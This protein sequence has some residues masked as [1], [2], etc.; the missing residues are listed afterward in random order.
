MRFLRILGLVFI[1]ARLIGHIACAKACLN[2]AARCRHRFG[3]HV[4]AIGA[5]IGDMPCLIQALRRRHAGLG[6][7][8]KLA[9]CFLLQGAGHKGRVRVAR[10]GLGFDR[11]HC[12]IALAHRRCRQIGRLGA[13]NVKFIQLFARQMGQFCGKAL[14]ARRGQQRG[15]GPEFARAKGLDLHLAV[16]DQ[17]QANRLHPPCRPRA[18]Q[19]APQHGGKVKPHQI[20]QRTA[21]QIGIAQRHIH[22]ARMFH[23]LG[24]GIFG[25]GVERHARDGLALFQ[26]A[27]QRLLQMP[28]NRLAFAVRVGCKDQLIVGFQRLGNG[29]DMLFAVGR[30]FP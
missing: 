9:G 15:D 28:R 11:L 16:N 17:P 6:P 20:I 14:P 1:Q 29:A 7:H 23:R 3:G 22:L 10:C 25:D 12:Q 26:A 5:H 13:G 21:G 8:A 27:V 19:L 18:W 30:H 4:N 24:H 2:R